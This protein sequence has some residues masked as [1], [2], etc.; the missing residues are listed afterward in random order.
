MK[1]TE[2]RDLYL[3]GGPVIIIQRLFTKE[4]LDGLIQIFVSWPDFVRH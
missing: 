3:I 4:Y 1:D 2:K